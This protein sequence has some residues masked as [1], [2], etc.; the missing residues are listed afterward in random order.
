[1]SCKIAR[2]VSEGIYRIPLRRLAQM[3]FQSL[4]VDDVDR[5]IE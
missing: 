4:A 3:R 2:S 5:F 1:M